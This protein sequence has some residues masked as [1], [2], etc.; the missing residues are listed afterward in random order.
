MNV[1]RR[2]PF[3]KDAHGGLV[4]HE[5]AVRDDRAAWLKEATADHRAGEI[6]PLVAVQRQPNSRPAA[7][8]AECWLCAGGDHDGNATGKI[9]VCAITTCA[10]WLLRP[11]QDTAERKAERATAKAGAACP[12]AGKVLDPVA[13][14]KTRPL[15]NAL[16]VRAYCWQC[17]GE[18]KNQNTRRDVA[19]CPVAK[20]G[21][22]DV[23]PWQAGVAAET[24]AENTAGSDDDETE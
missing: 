19:E 17:Q 8:R 2:K 23:R 9:K 14:L 21:L 4:F 11:Y 6:N 20:C 5:K 15:S 18:G 13:R 10:L 7:I 16:A 1:A 22:W 24:E 3:D 12:E